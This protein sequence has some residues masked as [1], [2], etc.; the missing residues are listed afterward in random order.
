MASSRHLVITVHG[1][2]TLGRWQERLEALLKN[3]DS[4]IEVFNYK[5]GYFSLLASRF[6]LS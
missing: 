6:S 1:I 5:Y 2:R 3:A 4:S